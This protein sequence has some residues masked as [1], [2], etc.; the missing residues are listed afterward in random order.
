MRVPTWMPVLAAS[1]VGVPGP[2]VSAEAPVAVSP[3]DVTAEQIEASC[4][5][6]S[7]GK[8]DGARVYELVL[9]RVAPGSETAELI[10]TQRVPGAA[11]AWTP[12]LDRCLSRGEE[13]AWAVRAVGDE[14]PG[15]WSTPALFTVAEGPSEA[16]LT[17]ALKVIERYGREGDAAGRSSS[18]SVGPSNAA[19]APRELAAN[20]AP[21]ASAVAVGDPAL[22][23][24]GAAVVTAASLDGALCQSLTFR[25]LDR[26]DGTV[27]DCNTGLIWL[28][29]AQCLGAAYWGSVHPNVFDLV[30]ELD[31]GTDF[32]CSNY[33]AGTY[34]DWR[35]PDMGELCGLW[36]GSCTGTSCCSAPDGIVDTRFSFPAVANARGDAQWSSDDAFVGVQN[37]VYWSATADNEISAIWRV[38]LSTGDLQTGIFNSVFW[39]WPVRGP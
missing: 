9:F 15:P 36:N 12:S 5:T 27:L 37:S 1:L 13:Y 28:K 6:F 22:Q 8:V 24:N 14:D 31:A 32:G 25:Y 38:S 20:R 34:S 11:S 7:W 33:V 10:W 18:R 29:D 21:E 26:G 2:L 4:P 16:D 3:G 30:S 23:V 17:Q 19:A 35:I 39:A